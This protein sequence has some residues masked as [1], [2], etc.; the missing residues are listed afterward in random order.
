[1]IYYDI[2]KYQGG[3]KVLVFF[4]KKTMQSMYFFLNKGWFYALDNRYIC[5]G[6]QTVVRLLT[7]T[8]NVN[9]LKTQ[10]ASYACSEYKRKRYLS[11]N[12]VNV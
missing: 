7:K 9:I 11:A 2:S 12:G 4:N 8:K 5:T 1:M 6:N 10:V 3:G